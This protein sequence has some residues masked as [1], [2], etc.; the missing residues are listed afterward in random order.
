MTDIWA[1]RE[2]SGWGRVPRATMLCARAD[3]PRDVAAALAA[4]GGEPMIAHGL[5]RSYGDAAM[6]RGGRVVFTRRLDRMLAFDEAS[7]VVRVEAGVSVEDLILAFLP[8]GFFP[9]VVP[10]T[11]FVTVGGAIAAD[12]HGKNHHV[13]GSFGDHVRAIDILVASG[14]VVHASRDENADLF[15][16]T[17][18]GMGLT[19]VILSA[20]FAMERVAGPLID[21]E[22][23]KFENLDEYFAVNAESDAFSHTVSWID[24]TT[25][26]DAMGRGIYMR[27]RHSSV[28]GA[29]DPFDAGVVDDAM[30]LVNARPFEANWLLN[31]LSI[32]AFNTA[33]FNKQLKKRVA[34]Q[35]HFKSFFFPLDS[36]RGWN[37]LY[38]DRGFMQY[39][40]VVPDRE[41]VREVLTEIT[42]AGMAS[43]LAVIKDFG[44]TCNGGL[45]FPRP[46]TTLALDFPNHGAPL[47]ALMERLDRIVATA[48]GRVYLAKDARM[49]RDTFREMY[50]DWEAWRDVKER[51]D[52]NHHFQ[53][54]QGLRLGLCGGASS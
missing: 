32:R 15:A 35:A 50:P 18:G 26:G 46:G 37:H 8:R 36:V 33:Y 28:L 23:I 34:A 48:G 53:S 12:I 40:M 39:Q 2:V 19:G 7:G 51:W 29:G 43:F 3:H 42:G 11:W 31:G 47:L 14:D 25:R 22:S 6:M 16:A 38:G 41:A 9:P 54:E 5:G 27:G 49:S 30:K 45:S 21:M 4:R 17:I 10:G 1:E 24:C 13:A 44:A 52:P 20:E